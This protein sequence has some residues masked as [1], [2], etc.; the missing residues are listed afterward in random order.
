MEID[1]RV[2][3]AILIFSLLQFYS[4]HAQNASGSYM[5]TRY[6]Q[7]LA[8]IGDEYVTKYEVIVEQEING[9][10]Q[11]RLSNFTGVEYIEISLPPGNYRFRV[12][13][14][15]F[16]DL[17]E[18]GTEW[19]EFIIL[20]AP[21]PEEVP[22]EPEQEEPVLANAEDTESSEKIIAEE[23]DAPE[24]TDAEE[25]FSEEFSTDEKTHAEENVQD[26]FIATET[27]STEPSHEIQESDFMGAKSFDFFVSAFFMPSIPFY[28]KIDESSKLQDPSLFGTSIRLGTLFTKLS[29]FHPG[30]ELSVR[31]H[32]LDI[33]K[34]MHTIDAECNFLI[35]K[36]MFNNKT[37]LTLRFGAGLNVLA[38]PSENL[39]PLLERFY[40]NIGFAFSWL[41]LN[42]FYFEAGFDYSHQF[43]QPAVSGSL[44]P[45]IGVGTRF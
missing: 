25:V 39:P 37:A 10:Y 28:E 36:P 33:E 15:D 29:L 18:T 4:L 8:W 19:K 16:R 34:D 5:E 2:L 32:S 9:E 12:I 23:D 1:K 17:P 41:P 31:W 38:L 20:P 6:I 42:H 27:S 40:A 35:Q 14:Y 13:P 30:M 45:F 43:T 7:R 26:E 24:D 44:H 11:F 21:I 3:L 22:P